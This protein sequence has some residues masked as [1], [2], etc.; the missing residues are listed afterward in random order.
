MHK[1]R[2]WLGIIKMPFPLVQSRLWMLPVG[3][4]PP[5][6]IQ[7]SPPLPLRGTPPHSVA[8]VSQ[9]TPLPEPGAAGI[10]TGSYLLA[11]CSRAPSTSRKRALTV[12][13][14]QGAFVN[15]QIP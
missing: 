13:Q 1:S 4:R 7:G 3:R 15:L 6:V 2:V 5:V 14:L 8:L 12:P 9:S 11:D 10:L